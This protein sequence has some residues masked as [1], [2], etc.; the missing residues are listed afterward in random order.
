MKELDQLGL[1]EQENSRIEEKITM[2][3]VKSEYVNALKRR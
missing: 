3:K 1:E 2:K